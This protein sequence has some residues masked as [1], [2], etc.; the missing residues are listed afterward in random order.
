MIYKV[1]DEQVAK[2]EEGVMLNMN[3]GIVSVHSHKRVAKS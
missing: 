2:G 1:L 3:S